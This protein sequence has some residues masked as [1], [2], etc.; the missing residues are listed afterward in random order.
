MAWRDLGG[1]LRGPGHSCCDANPFLVAICTE[2]HSQR[3]IVALV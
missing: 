2:Q 1:F 3:K